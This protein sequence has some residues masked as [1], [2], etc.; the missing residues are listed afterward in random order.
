MS[1]IN[2]EEWYASR[3]PVSTLPGHKSPPPVGAMCDHDGHE[4]IPAKVRIQGETDSMGAEYGFL[5][6]A[7]EKEYDAAPSAESSCD[8][9]SSDDVLIPTRFPDEGTS[10]PVYYLCRGCRD[11]MFSAFDD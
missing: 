6:E 8:H 5:C 3:G 4:H 7:C 1:E 9:C 10:G 2:K 11:K